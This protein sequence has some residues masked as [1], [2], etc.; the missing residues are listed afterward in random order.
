MLKKCMLQLRAEY[1]ISIVNILI[2]NNKQI[3]HC[4]DTEY[5][6]PSP[7][8]DTFGDYILKWSQISK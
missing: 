6:V 7:V 1:Y 5:W 4:D 3:S 2:S 8:S